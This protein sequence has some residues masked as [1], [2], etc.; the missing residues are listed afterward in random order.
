MA[1]ATKNSTSD[2]ERQGRHDT[3]LGDSWFASVDVIVQMKKHLNARFIGVIKTNHSKFPKKWLET[4]MKDWP[5]GSHL[6]LE[7]T[8]EGVDIIACGY[9]YNKR[10]VCCFVF[11]KGAGRCCK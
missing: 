6:V 3:Y 9:K 7:A 2:D 5:P 8:H 4:T 1:K 10:K 11:T